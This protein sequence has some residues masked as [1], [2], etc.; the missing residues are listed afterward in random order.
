LN[1]IDLEIHKGERLGIIGAN[2]AGKSTLLKLLSRITAPTEGEIEIWGRVS[3]MLEVGTGFHG[4]MTGRENIYM[5]GAILGMSRSEIDAKM[6][7][8]IEFSEV[9]DFIDTPVKRYSS[10]MFV[11]LAFAVAANLNSQIMIMDEVLAVGDMAFQNKCLTRMRRNADEEGRTILYVSHNMQ[12]IRTLCERCIVLN[13]GKIVFDGD[14]E[15]A[16]AVYMKTGMDDSETEVDLSDRAFYSRR[17]QT[18]FSLK[19]MS[20]TDKSI[21]VYA[22][23]ENLRMQL[24]VSVEKPVDHV[25][26][27]AILMNDASVRLGSMWTPEMQFDEPGDYVVSIVIPLKQVESGEFYSNIGFYLQDGL[28]SESILDQAERAL[29]FEVQPTTTWNQNIRGYLR[30]PE[31]ILS[32]IEKQ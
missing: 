3:S 21:P 31:M 16:I 19:H 32:G 15:K 7:E 29:H 24:T 26:F 2:G 9:R 17:Y 27:R 13:Q 20:L 5:N 6:E 12:T 22:P 1:G 10:G 25:A 18:G 23:D 30:L 4:E 14:V 8:I 11:K 28:G